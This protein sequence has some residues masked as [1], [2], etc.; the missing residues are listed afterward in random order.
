MLGSPY[1]FGTPLASELDFDEEYRMDLAKAFAEV[2]LVTDAGPVLSL[3]DH[4]PLRNYID[5]IKYVSAREA[6]NGQNPITD[7]LNPLLVNLG[8]PPL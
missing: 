8:K 3:M 7:H 6:C 1:V 2:Y 5:P 4:R